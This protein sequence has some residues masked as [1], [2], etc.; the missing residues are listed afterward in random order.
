MLSLPL[1]IVLKDKIYVLIL[2]ICVLGSGFA[3]PKVISY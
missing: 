3:N 2:D 1:I